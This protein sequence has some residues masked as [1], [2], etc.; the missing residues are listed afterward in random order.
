MFHLTSYIVHFTLFRARDLLESLNSV[1]VLDDLDSVGCELAAGNQL[2]LGYLTEVLAVEL[3]ALAPYDVDLLDVIDGEILGGDCAFGGEAG[4]KGSHFA[5]RHAVAFEDELLEA[6]DCLG[7]DSCDVAV[8]IDTAVVGDVLCEL[9]QAEI[10]TD[11]SDAKCLC[12]IAL[13]GLLRSG[14]LAPD[15]N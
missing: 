1:R 11:L 12:G 5:Q 2:E 15:A 8:V 7:E 6:E 4:A 10:L 13:L 14:L 3:K 9:G